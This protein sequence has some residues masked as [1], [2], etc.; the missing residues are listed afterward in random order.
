MRKG[1][2]TGVINTTGEFII[3][4]I[5]DDADF[6]APE[7][8]VSVKKDRKWGVIDRSGKIIIPLG[9]EYISVFINGYVVTGKHVTNKGYSGILCPTVLNE[10]NE[11]IF[12]VGQQTASDIEN[13]FQHDYTQLFLPGY[14]NKKNN[15]YSTGWPMVREGIL[16][17]KEALEGGVEYANFRAVDVRT[18]K[19]FTFN[20]GLKPTDDSFAFREGTMAMEIPADRREDNSDTRM[21]FY[22]TA[23]VTTENMGYPIFDTKDQRVRPFFNGVAA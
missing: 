7:G 17:L 11:V 9:H 16:V 15:A 23:N 22:D 4:P 13:G 3:N 14:A 18:G 10:K 6:Y 5:Y 8:M 21:G 12:T 2:K 20:Y 19:A 1:K